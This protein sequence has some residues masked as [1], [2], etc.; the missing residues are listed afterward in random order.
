MKKQITITILLDISS[1]KDISVVTKKVQ[2]RKQKRK[3]RKTD[4][5]Y[6]DRWGKEWPIYETTNGKLFIV[7]NGRSGKYKH[8]VK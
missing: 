8:Y 7:R 1:A 3:V 5:N 6:T 4:T 2:R